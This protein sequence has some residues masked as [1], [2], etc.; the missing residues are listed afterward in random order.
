MTAA[1]RKRASYEDILAADPR[2]IAEIV[3]G[4][5]YTQ[6]RPALGHALVASELTY[7]LIGP[8]RHG[9]GGPGGWHILVEPELHLGPEPDILV[10]DLAGWRTSRMP[11]VSNRAFETLAPDWVAEIL[12]PSTSRIDR[13]MKL[14]VYLRERVPHVW[15][16]DPQA[17]TI[18]VLRLDGG[19]YRLLGV[20]T[21]DD[22]ARLEPFDEIELDC[23]TLWLE[24]DETTP[25]GG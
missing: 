5:L 14:P 18:E 20:H 19:S 12:S 1:A 13:S 21:D 11:R 17:M 15:L 7:R 4:V 16:L 8:F 10:P 23:A 9:R 24:D 6:P 25:S 22:R 2:V 3:D